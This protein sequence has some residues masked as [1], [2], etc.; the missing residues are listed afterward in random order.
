MVYT[1]A[2]LILCCLWHCVKKLVYCCSGQCGAR[3]QLHL[4]SG[5][6]AEKTGGGDDTG[7]AAPHI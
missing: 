7:A 6:G 1:I 2:L 4:C 3:G 5:R